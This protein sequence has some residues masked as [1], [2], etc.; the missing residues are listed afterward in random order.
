MTGQV[1]AAVD[2][3]AQAI[4]NA[5]PTTDTPADIKTLAE[6][7]AALQFGPQG[8]AGHVDYRY[9]ADCHTTNHD[10]ERRERPTGFGSET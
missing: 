9:Q 8:Y 3:V 4:S 7:A 5:A 1:R 6:A 2:A 10:G